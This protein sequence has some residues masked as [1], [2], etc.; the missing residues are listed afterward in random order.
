MAGRKTLRI[1]TNGHQYYK[2]SDCPACPVCESIK[3]DDAF[4]AILA[5]PARRALA[6]AGIK[7]VSQLAGYSQSDLLKLHGLG[8]GS[9]PKLKSL[10]KAR[11]LDFRH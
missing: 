10:L 5:A 3:D 9:I 6:N 7:S 8:P 4:N 1:C 11:G 2:V